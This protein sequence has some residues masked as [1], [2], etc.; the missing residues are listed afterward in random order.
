MSSHDS[1]SGCYNRHTSLTSGWQ[2]YRRCSCRRPLGRTYS[3]PAASPLVSTHYL[4]WPQGCHGQSYRDNPSPASCP[5]TDGHR[6]SPR[7]AQHGYRRS[8]APPSCPRPSCRQDSDAHS[9]TYIFRW[10]SGIRHSRCCSPSPRS[11]AP[12]M[13]TT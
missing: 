2:T 3:D 9:G 6:G 11:F 8:D 4:Q 1:R 12:T 5:A 10:P 7:Y 13:P